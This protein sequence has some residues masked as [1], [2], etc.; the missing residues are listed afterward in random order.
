MMSISLKSTIRQMVVKPIQILSFGLLLIPNHSWAESVSQ[1]TIAIIIDDM[2]NHLKTGRQLIDLPYPLTLAFLPHRKHTPDLAR[3]AHR[4]HKEIMLHMPMAN[5]LGLELGAGGLTVDMTKPDLTNTLRKA[6][7]AIPYVQGIN[8]HMGSA[9]TQRK[10]EMGW[11]MEELYNYPL[12]FVDSRTIASSIAG[13]TAQQHRIPSLSRDV[14]LDHWQTRESIHNQFNRLIQVAKEKG[15]A[16]A[17]GHPHQVTAD[18]LE[19]ALP[20]LD[21]QGIRIATISGLWAIRNNGQGMFSNRK[22]HASHS[23][24]TTTNE[25]NNK[26]LKS[27]NKL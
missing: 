21:Q 6:I 13:T 17:I 18:Y 8:N 1:P 5:T 15:T 11:V 23:F 22:Q 14:F 24:A 20:K 7:Q 4:L 27:A 19:W 16:I 25:A 3:S 12:Y 26:K 10:T 2:G 9:L